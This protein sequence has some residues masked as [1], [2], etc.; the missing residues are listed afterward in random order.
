MFVIDF[1]LYFVFLIIIKFM[2]VCERR[3]GYTG[4][5]IHK[6]TLFLING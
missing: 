3:P 5:T 2:R 1:I 4:T 6:I